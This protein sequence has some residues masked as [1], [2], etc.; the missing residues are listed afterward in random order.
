MKLSLSEL[1][2]IHALQIAPR[3]SWKD[4]GEVLGVH[5]VTV[6]ERWAQIRAAGH[7]WV[8]GYRG[9][10][11]TNGALAFVGLQCAHGTRD[12][13]L[14]R[15][16]AISQVSHVEET[17]RNWDFRLT[18]MANDWHEISHTVFPQV[19]QDPDV[20]RTHLAVAT[21]NI[22]LGHEWRLDV[23]DPAQERRLKALHP[24]T[25]RDSAPIPHLDQMLPL[26]AQ[27]GR[28]SAAEVAEAIGVHPTTAARYI[29]LALETGALVI[30]CELAQQYSG[31][32]VACEWWARVPAGE[33]A[34]AEKYLQSFRSLRLA[35][36]TTG[37]AN[38]NFYIWLRH[39]AEIEEV[40][41]GLQRAAPG[42]QILES[43]IGVRTHKRMGW[44]LGPDTTATGEFT[45]PRR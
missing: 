7:A 12:A 27:N 28:V 33:L 43:E 34:E 23:L 8:T 24:V 13:V 29:R 30:R 26:L 10:S 18:V 36:V 38:L 19:R 35:A 39:L 20:V 41:L 31:Y 4:L 15:M 14:E 11:P 25:P 16:C 45:I 17:T 9:F 42:T 21:R 1:E 3:A 6:A 22:A 2:L 5:P 40:E 44:R 32:P 37:D